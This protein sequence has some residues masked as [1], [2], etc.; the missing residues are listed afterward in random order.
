MLSSNILS[1]PWVI[2][3]NDFFFGTNFEYETF[4]KLTNVNREKVA[5]NS[6]RINLYRASIFGVYGALEGF[7]LAFSVPLDSYQGSKNARHELTGI[8]DVALEGKYQLLYEER[9]MPFSLAL[10]SSIKVPVARFDPNELAAPGDRTIDGDLRLHLGRYLTFG[11][12]SAYWSLE[13]GYNL[14]LD[15]LSD[16]VLALLELGVNVTDSLSFALITEG[17]YGLGGLQIGSAEYVSIVSDT[18]FQPFDKIGPS[19]LKLGFSLSFQ[20]TATVVIG[21]VLSTTAV[22]KSATISHH[23]NLYVGT[24]L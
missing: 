11:D 2:Q 16:S 7:N 14:R 8:G 10:S 20:A 5:I 17:L 13:V 15:G 12:T 23:I 22:A 1:S 4:N 24:Q 19:Y 21:S 18:G 9:E 3:Q 6:K